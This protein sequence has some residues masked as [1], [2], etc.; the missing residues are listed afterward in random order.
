GAHPALAAAQ[1]RVRN[2]LAGGSMNRPVWACGVLALALAG[3]SPEPAAPPSAG[4]P[5]SAETALP[6]AAAAAPN[7]A[8]RFVEWPVYGGNLA[9]HRYSPL[10]Q[11]DRN[12]VGSLEIAWR[13]QAGN[14]GPRPEQRNEATPLMQGGVLYMTAGMTRNVA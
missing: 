10:D 2:R 12:N 1:T 14:F 11:I 3:C 8:G 6:A 13:W 5:A 7:D 4:A 9:S